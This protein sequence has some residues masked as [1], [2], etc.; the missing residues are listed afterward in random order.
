MLGSTEDELIE[1]YMCLEQLKRNG[2]CGRGAE[3]QV[4]RCYTCL[5]SGRCIHKGCTFLGA[6]TC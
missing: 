4:L 3:E 2:I 1:A 5:L 6:A